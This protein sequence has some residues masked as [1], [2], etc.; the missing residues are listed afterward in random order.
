[1]RT[2]RLPAPW[3]CAGWLCWAQGTLIYLVPDRAK[4]GYGLS[5]DVVRQALEFE[6]DL[7]VTVDNGISSLAGVGVCP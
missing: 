4:H 6:P 3:L 7:L 2:A 1:M 5:T